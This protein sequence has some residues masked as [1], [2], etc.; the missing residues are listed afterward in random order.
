MRISLDV[1]GVIDTHPELFAAISKSLVEQGHEIHIVT[2]PSQTPEFEQYLRNLGIEYSHFC[3]IID[4][5]KAQGITVTYDV[6][7]QGWVRPEQWDSAKADYC[8]LNKID[9]HI[10]D[11]EIYGLYFTTPYLKIKDLMKHTS[12]IDALMEM[13]NER[14]TA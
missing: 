3:S 14:R 2:G 6:R 5:R 9:L 10:D 11:S 13:L 12:P 8:A 1:H 4:Y 7:G